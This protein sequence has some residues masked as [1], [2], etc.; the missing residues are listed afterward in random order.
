MSF[1]YYRTRPISKEEFQAKAESFL[2][3]HP[4]C[5]PV[6]T[7]GMTKQEICT[8]WWGKSW[9]ENLE[10]YAEWANR[11]NLGRGYARKGA[12]VDLTINGGDIHAFVFGSRPDPYE[13]NVKIYPI[14]SERQQEIE[15]F[16][17]GRIQ[18]LEEL[19]SGNFPEGLKG[20]FF[21]K[22]VLF[23]RPDEIDFSC[24]CSDMSYMCRH[25]IAALYGIGV[26]LDSNPLYFFEMRGIDTEKFISNIVNGK[27]EKM[28]A[29]VNNYSPRILKDADLIELFNVDVDG[30]EMKPQLPANDDKQEL[31]EET[32]PAPDVSDVEII[33][34]AEPKPKKKLKDFTDEEL[35]AVFELIKAI[36]PS[37]AAI[38]AN[39][40]L[41]TAQTIRKKVLLRRLSKNRVKTQEMPMQPK[42]KEERKEER[43]AVNNIAQPTK[44]EKKTQ[45]VPLFDIKALKEQILRLKV[46]NALLKTKTTMLLSQL[47]KMKAAISCLV[48]YR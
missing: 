34:T 27:I 46:E 11:I 13:V 12:V 25:V 3:A 17:A 44:Q 32:K 23:P 47:N 21:Q 30:Q 39:I 43:I 37:K 6:E 18:S 9:C 8:S 4:D 28:L 29:N 15:K 7:A 38:E 20:V 33:E 36:G 2:Q 19:I 16:A 31:K 45:P 26:R 10:R 42:P 5:K 35:E 1:Y 14:S 48:E 41:G 22:G 24:T 40:T